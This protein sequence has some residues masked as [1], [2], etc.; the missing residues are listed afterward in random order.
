[1]SNFVYLSKERL[2]EIEDEIKDLKTNGRKQ[3][4]E[5]IAEAR[6]HGDLSENAEYDAAKE[7][8]GLLELKISKIEDLLTRARII[9]TS[10]MPLDKVHILSKVKVKNL[11]NSKTF[12]YILVSPEEADLEKGKIAMTSPVGSSLMGKQVGDKVPA[13]VPAGVI[14]FEILEIN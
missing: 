5:R 9:D 4:A 7:E 11:N 8:Q 14:N 12:E 2:K 13:K 1:M 3:M 10:S 6:A